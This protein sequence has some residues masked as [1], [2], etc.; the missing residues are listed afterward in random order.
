[1]SLT[2]TLTGTEGLGG[3]WKELAA[4]SGFKILRMSVATHL[5]SGYV[6]RYVLNEEKRYLFKGQMY[7]LAL[8]FIFSFLFSCT[9]QHDNQYSIDSLGTVINGI[10]KPT[11]G[12]IRYNGIS[13][14]E[15]IGVGANSVIGPIGFNESITKDYIEFRFWGYSSFSFS[16][17]IVLKYKPESRSWYLYRLRSESLLRKTIKFDKKTIPLHFFDK[18]K[19]S[20]ELNKYHNMSIDEEDNALKI[21]V[22]TV[23]V[24]QIY[25]NIS[26]NDVWEKLLNLRLLDLPTSIIRNGLPMNDG[27]GFSY[28]FIYEA[29]YRKG[30]L[31]KWPK[32]WK[33]YNPEYDPIPIKIANFLERVY[34]IELVQE[35]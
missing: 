21:Y 18:V 28:E 7:K 33:G 27:A 31:Q 35:D 34:R 25:P 23:Y 16:N 10:S 11:D 8:L 2:I 24:E 30:T 29:T 13:E 5:Q 6:C 26:G 17:G 3:F 19:D 14:D 4:K 22:D 15:I 9:D 1:M 12:L 20:L 32:D